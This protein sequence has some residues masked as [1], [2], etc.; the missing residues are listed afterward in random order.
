MEES[1]LQTDNRPS[2]QAEKTEI[3]ICSKQNSITKP[4]VRNWSRKHEF[5]TKLKRGNEKKK[6]WEEL[7]G[8]FL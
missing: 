2:V 3:Y 4:V 5:D 7:I 1:S 8:Y 6:F